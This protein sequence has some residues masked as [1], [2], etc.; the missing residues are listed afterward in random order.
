M[1]KIYYLLGILIP[2]FGTILGSS[3][4]FLL[5]NKINN[6]LEKIMIG[7]AIGVMLCASIF[8]LL[9][10]SIELS[11][12]NFK[13]LEAT[14]GFIIGFLL[15]MIINLL[16]NKIDKLLFSVTLHNIPEG[17]SVGVC[18]V[19]AFLKEI[20]FTSALLLSFGIALQNIPEG[21]IISFPLKIKG[22]N[23]F[24]SFYYGFLSGVVEPLAS[25]ITIIL[26]KYIKIILPYSLSFASG[27]MIYVIIDELIFKIN[28][29]DKIYGIIGFL[30]GF[31]IMLIL[32]ISF[33]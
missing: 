29:K 31:I 28:D 20:S 23:N 5:K 22:N 4:V 12:S 1:N 13:C 25:I 30:I 2:L 10:P 24:K 27:C 3:F 32:D 19:S 18:F 11:N 6:K 14:I 21:M 7:F 9:I 33:G 15:L 26:I 8:S 16:D 17:L